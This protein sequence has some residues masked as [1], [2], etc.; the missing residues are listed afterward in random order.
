M[1]GFFILSPS[2]NEYQGGGCTV[3]HGPGNARRFINLF[4]AEFLTMKPIYG[5]LRA[6]TRAINR[7]FLCIVVAQIKRSKYRKTFESAADE[8]KGVFV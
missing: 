6:N 8:L 3:A 5:V 7:R 2:R 1:L 4:S